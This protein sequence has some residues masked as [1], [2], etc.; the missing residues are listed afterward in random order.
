MAGRRLVLELVS[1]LDGEPL[2][3]IPVVSGSWRVTDEAGVRVPGSIAFTVP[4]RPEWIPTTPAHP[5][6]WYGQRVRASIG[7]EGDPLTTWGWYRLD[8]PRVS[9][10][11]VECTGT[12]LLRLVE[13]ARFTQSWQTTAGQTRAQVARALLAGILPVAA[14]GVT[15]EV[16][17]V[18][19]WSDDRLAAFWD[20]VESW[21]ARVVMDE[22]TVTI[23]PA[24]NDTSPGSPAAELV[25]GP[26]GSLT[27]PLEPVAGGDDPFNGYVVSNVPEGDTAATVRFW[28]MPDGPMRWGGPYGQN[29]GFF[30]SPLNPADPVKLLAIG[31]RMTRREVAAG[32]AFKFQALPDPARRVGDVV[33]LQARAQGVHGLARITALSFTRSVMGGTVSL[34]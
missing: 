10:P 7:W 16:L 6:A 33:T 5:L 1:Y 14:A 2:A 4:A 24:W 21:P 30:S 23:V 3:T 19:T 18:V 31:E 17:P 25:D 34:L 8:R 15:D 32:R 28:G 12:G 22:Q 9:R 11:L 26:G 20:V 13:R 29:P 27:A